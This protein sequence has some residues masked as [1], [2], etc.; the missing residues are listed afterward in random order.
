MNFYNMGFLS[1]SAM[2]D[3]AHVLIKDTLKA[4]DDYKNKHQKC[5]K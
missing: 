2:K 5:M 3:W 4:F 1:N